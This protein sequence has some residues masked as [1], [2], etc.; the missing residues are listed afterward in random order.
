MHIAFIFAHIITMTYLYLKAL[1]IIFVVTWFAGLFYM[2]RL[3][4]YAT[5]ASQKVEPEKSILLKQM[6]LMQ[7]RLWYIIA[8][9][10]AIITLAVGTWLA[11]ESAFWTMPWFHLKVLFVLGLFLYHFICQK[12]YN[13]MK[14][15]IFK[16]SSTQ[17]RIWNEVATLFLFAI[18]FIVVLKSTLN[19]IWGVVGIILIGILLMLGIKIYKKLRND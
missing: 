10:S 1:H 14:R 19:W 8:W 17:L 18:V 4:I 11:I 12:L 6:L 3:F 15:E 7:G 13:Q 16:Y 2:V 5:E 9:P